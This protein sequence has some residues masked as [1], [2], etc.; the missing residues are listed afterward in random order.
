MERVMIGSHVEG[1]KFIEEKTRIHSFA[2]TR[3]LDEFSPERIE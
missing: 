3:F 1:R 2:P